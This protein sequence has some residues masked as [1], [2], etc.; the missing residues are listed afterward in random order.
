MGQLCFAKPQWILHALVLV[1]E[2]LPMLLR[3]DPTLEEDVD[4]S[5]GGQSFFFQSLD[6]AKHHWD[7]GEIL[8]V[9]A[10][11]PVHGKDWLVSSSL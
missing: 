11:F 5:P 7:L 6:L 8:H 4:D 2:V 9:W 1:A 10:S 3:L